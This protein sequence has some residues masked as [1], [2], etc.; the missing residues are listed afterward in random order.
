MRAKRSKSGTNPEQVQSM[1]NDR[2]NV[3]KTL[4]YQ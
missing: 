2:M 1:L 4:N 3:V